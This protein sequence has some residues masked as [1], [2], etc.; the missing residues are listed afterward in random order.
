MMGLARAPILSWAESAHIVQS[1][2]CNQL[3]PHMKQSCSP[4]SLDL[5]PV[6]VLVPLKS[7]CN[8]DLFMKAPL[9]VVRRL[10]HQSCQR[11][12]SSICLTRGRK[13]GFFFAMLSGLEA[14]LKHRHGWPFWALPMVLCSP[15]LYAHSGIVISHW[16]RNHH[17]HLLCEVMTCTH[18]IWACF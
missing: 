5:L 13:K 7:P 12:V 14:V 3:N 4:L 10:I 8:L 15:V 17:H 18:W 9:D 1:A 16:V 11:Q 2:I 6:R